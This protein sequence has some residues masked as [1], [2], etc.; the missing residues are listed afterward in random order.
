M[1]K[2]ITGLEGV[3]THVHGNDQY[4][5]KVEVEGTERSVLCYLCGKMKK[6]RIGVLVNDQV[7][8]TVPPP[9]DRGRITFRGKEK[10]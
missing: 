6:H 7:V 10:H 8:I 1:S 5:V 2:T 9:Y 3:V 4:N